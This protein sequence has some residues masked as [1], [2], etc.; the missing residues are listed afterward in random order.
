MAT[1]KS[2][3]QHV[4]DAQG[5]AKQNAT[6]EVRNAGTMTK[7][8]IYGT[9]AGPQVGNP[10]ASDAQGFFEFYLDPD[11]HVLGQRFDLWIQHTDLSSKLFENI[12]ILGDVNA[13]TEQE[14]TGTNAVL[15]TQGAAK[16]PLN[17]DIGT[18][19]LVGRTDGNMQAVD[20]ADLM[21]R[22]HSF[23]MRNGELP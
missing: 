1:R 13:I 17:L 11:D 12:D 6:I 3:F 19:Q 15:A 18:E 7:T 20:I 2:Y 21:V 16:T 10:L 14:F 8:V 23:A 9:L 22:A 4:Q 5:N